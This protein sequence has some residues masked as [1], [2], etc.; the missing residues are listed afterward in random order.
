MFLFN[1]QNCSESSLTT[2]TFLLF[3]ISCLLACFE[4]CKQSP[5][6]TKQNTPV[7]FFDP[8]EYGKD[9]PGKLSIETRFS[10]CGE[11]GGHKE[12][13][14]V[15]ADSNKVFRADY[16]VYPY[17]CD[18]ITYYYGN[19]NLEPVMVK[20]VA[21]GENEKKSILDYIRRLTQSKINERLID[22]LSNTNNVFSIVN[23]DSTLF[24][25]VR[26]QKEVDMNSYKK[27]VSELYK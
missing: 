23:F 4:A 15:Y 1:Y 14:S 13:I 8:I 27:L 10:E 6:T 17:N 16:R 5:K 9:I 19:R 22:L 12:E 24:I 20:T 3:L 7:N 11:W 2:K 21:L 26:N 25:K 18:S